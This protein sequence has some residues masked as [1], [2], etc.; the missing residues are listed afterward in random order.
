VRLCPRKCGGS[1]Q[2]HPLSGKNSNVKL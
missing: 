2:R 1:R